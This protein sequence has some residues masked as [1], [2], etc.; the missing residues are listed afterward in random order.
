[1][2]ILKIARMGHP[3]LTGK[4]MKVDDPTSSSVR[5]LAS[6]MLETMIDAPG[7]GLAAPQVHVPLRVIAFRV[8]PVRENDNQSLAAKVIIN[9]EINDFQYTSLG[10]T[11]MVRTDPSHERKR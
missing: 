11:F 5:R 3:I 6:D 10:E 9:P 4:A 1:M 7:V 8:P 2:A